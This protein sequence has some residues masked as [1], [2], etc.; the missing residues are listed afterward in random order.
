MPFSKHLGKLTERTNVPLSAGILELVVAI[1]MMMVGGL[2][3][4]T[5]MLVFVIWIFY[6]MVFIGVII[7][8]K[9]EPSLKRPY[10]VPLYP[11]IPLIAII[12][13][14]FIVVSTLL[15]QTFLALSGIAMTLAG[16]PVYLYLKNKY[17]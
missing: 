3:M 11:I 1:L 4:L 8:R 6:T 13:G 12:G 16:I 5:D 15:T 10:K 2:D 7:L 9:T 14:G 17:S